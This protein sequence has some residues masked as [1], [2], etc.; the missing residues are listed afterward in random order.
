[1]SAWGHEL[2]RGLVWTSAASPQRP[3]VASVM[4]VIGTKRSLV[5]QADRNNARKRRDTARAALLQPARS[6]AQR[7][8]QVALLRKI[9]ICRIPA[10]R[11]GR[12]GRRFKS[13]HSDQ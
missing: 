7:R 13:C 9:G 12:G 1:M 10:P 2:K 8:C 3:D 4:S 11:S 6:T 5:G